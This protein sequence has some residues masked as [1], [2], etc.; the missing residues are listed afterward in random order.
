MDR[1]VDF[2]AKARQML[3]DGIVQHLENRMMQPAFI[4]VADIHSGAFSDCLQPLQFINF[5][6]VVFLGFV[7]R[8]IRHVT[9]SLIKFAIKNT[10]CAMDFWV[11]S[12]TP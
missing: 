7:W 10:L 5:R 12:A 3:V 1:N 4:G 2:I 9:I 8:G 6:R 11:S